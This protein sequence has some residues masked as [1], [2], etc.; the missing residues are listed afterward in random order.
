MHDKKMMEIVRGYNMHDYAHCFP[1]DYLDCGWLVRD[2]ETDENY[3]FIAIIE[4]LGM[5][6]N[7]WP[8]IK[9]DL[10]MRYINTEIIVKLYL[11]FYQRI[12]R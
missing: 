11:F 1:L 6:E 8:Q 10:R 9:R 7:S 2:V 5:G 3:G 12:N 4:L